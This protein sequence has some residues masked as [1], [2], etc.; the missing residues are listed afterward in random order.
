ML[1]SAPVPSKSVNKRAPKD[2]VREDLNAL[3]AELSS[4]PCFTDKE[5]VDVSVQMNLIDIGFTI[6]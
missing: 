1:L 6:I 2:R 4:L 3:E 5:G